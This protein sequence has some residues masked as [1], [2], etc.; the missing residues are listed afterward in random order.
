M[1]VV[2]ACLFISASLVIALPPYVAAAKFYRALQSGD[3]TLIQQAAYL[4]P[5]DRMRFLYVAQA[6]QENK[7]EFDAI[8]V[9]RDASQIYPDS[10]EI[11]Q[12]WSKI[13]SATAVEV[14]RAKAEMKRL[15]PYNP[16][17]K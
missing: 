8:T 12:R 7:Y 13:P 5:N 14:T 3:P 6:L 16:E 4:K 17:L 15:D 2:L 9:L 11:W 1:P 10:F